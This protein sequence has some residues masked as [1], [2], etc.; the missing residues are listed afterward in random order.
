M[1][2]TL[3]TGALALA[4]IGTAGAA[5]AATFDGMNPNPEFMTGITEVRA[6][7][8]QGTEVFIPVYSMDRCVDDRGGPNPCVW[9]GHQDGN[10]WGDSFVQ[11]GYGENSEIAY[12]TS[13]AAEI[14]PVDSYQSAPVYGTQQEVQS[15]EP[16][17]SPEPSSAVPVSGSSQDVYNRL[18]GQSVASELSTSTLPPC[19]HEDSNNC[20]WNASTMG[21]GIGRSFTDIMGEVFYW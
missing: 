13:W 11:V 4:S 2:K 6:V 8:E 14:L 5:H 18:T 1:R 3:T 19:E 9:V 10:G 7:T 17:A 21:N 16:V 12:I 20:Y 15:A